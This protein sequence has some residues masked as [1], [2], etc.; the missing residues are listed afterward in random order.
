MV[1]MKRFMKELN[2]LVSIIVITYNS[3]KYVLETIESAK[4]QTYQNIELI[5]SDDGSTDN[6]VEICREWIE[7]N[8]ERFVR[9]ELITVPENTG[10]PANCNRAWVASNGEW[11]KFIA[12]D[13]ELMPNCIEMNLLFTNRQSKILHSNCEIYN[14]KFDLVN[15][16]DITDKKDYQFCKVYTAIEQYR[17]LI[18]RKGN[19]SSP[20]VFFHRTILENVNGFDEDFRLIEDVPMWLKLTK[21]GYVFQFVDAITVKYRIHNYSVQR[22][23]QYHMS[24]VYA[25]ELLKVNVKYLRNEVSKFVYLKRTLRLKLIIILN[26]IKLNNAGVVSDFLF[27]CVNKI[28]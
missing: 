9:T 19:I 16:I 21:A 8:K 1:P 7:E 5:V 17:L 13:D 24:K 23:N 2:P 22:D 28:S 6:T 3:A 26:M 14:N 18:N 4:D 27:R 11:I 20:T 15:L 12:G 25:E 10:I